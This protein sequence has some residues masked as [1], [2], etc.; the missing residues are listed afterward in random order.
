MQIEQ[1]TTKIKKQQQ[2]F[3]CKERWV[4]RKNFGGTFWTK[5]K[6]VLLLKIKNQKAEKYKK[7]IKKNKK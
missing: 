5:S 6:K 2:N 4:K 7:K 1:A 3:L